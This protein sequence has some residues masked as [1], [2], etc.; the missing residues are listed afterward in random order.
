VK[1]KRN[2]YL[3][4]VIEWLKRYYS[5]ILIVLL[6]VMIMPLSACAAVQPATYPTLSPDQVRQGVVAAEA[7]AE[8][9][10]ILF[11]PGVG[12]IVSWLNNGSRVFVYALD[13][14]A[15]LDV[16]VRA[17]SVSLED[18]ANRIQQFINMGWQYVPIARM[19]VVTQSILDVMPTVMIFPLAPYE[20]TQKYFGNEAVQQ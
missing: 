15:S 16:Q 5:G 12:Y 7:E 8:N 3:K 20:S 6:V 17:I 18:S 19:V 14:G 9:G 4:Y 10:F 11:R 2:A 13:R 1:S